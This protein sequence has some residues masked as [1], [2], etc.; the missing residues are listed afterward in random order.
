MLF[1]KKHQTIIIACILLV[2]SLIV[3]SYSVKQPSEAGLFRKMVLEMAAPLVSAINIPINEVSTVWKRYL[4][5]VGLEEE[6]RLLK[7]ES[8]MLSNELL[9]YREGYLEG[10]RLQ[11]LLKLKESLNYPSIAARVIAK[12]QTTL[13]K[14][15]LIDKGTAEGL[16]I[17]LP[18]VAEKGV[19]GR[20]IESSWHSSRV[21]LLID[22]SSKIDASLQEGRSQGI[23]QGGG[24]GVCNL[25]YIPK[26]E[27]VKVGDVVISSGLSGVFPKG[28]FMG[29]V[30]SADKNEPGLFQK[31]QIVPYVDFAKLEE[32]LVLLPDKDNRK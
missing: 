10:I 16:K 13:I 24:A 15:I 14:T 6:N 30:T 27:T 1:H 9:Q 29:V 3:L 21:L 18:V 25:K 19:A 31:V 8:A 26:T 32:V 28:L 5:L 7:K 12:S 17:G 11:K 23:L 4:F 2:I 22:E 20:I